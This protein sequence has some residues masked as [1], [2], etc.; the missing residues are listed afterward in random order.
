MTFSDFIK[1]MMERTDLS[2]YDIGRMWYFYC[3]LYVDTDVINEDCE[4]C[5]VRINE[6]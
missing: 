5:E 6:I 3:N 2:N 1:R 4:D